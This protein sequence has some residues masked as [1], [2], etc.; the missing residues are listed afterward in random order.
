MLPVSEFEERVLFSPHIPSA[1]NNLLQQAVAANRSDFG[2]AEQLFKLA[3]QTDRSCLQTYFALY[4]FYFHHKRLH[5]A[6]SEIRAAL[7]EAA[8]QGGFPSDFRRLARQPLKWDL[9]ANEIGLYYLYTLKALAFVKLRKQQDIEAQVILTL[10]QDL[11]PEDR[12]GASVI[13][14]LAEAVE[15]SS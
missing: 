6:E 2:Q 7:E 14:S 3:K 11:D 10:L 9:C 5:D 13:R 15:E 12:C 8:R 1:V 4:K